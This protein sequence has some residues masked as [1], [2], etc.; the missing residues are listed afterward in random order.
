MLGFYL[1]S[2]MVFVVFGHI[3]YY[4]P[5]TL[6]YSYNI[7]H[8]YVCIY[9]STFHVLFYQLW[10]HE[11]KIFLMLKWCF[12]TWIWQNILRME[13]DDSAK[14]SSHSYSSGIYPFCFA[15]LLKFIVIHLNNMQTKTR[16]PYQVLNIL[17]PSTL[18]FLY[19]H[20]VRLFVC[21]ITDIGVYVWVSPTVNF[22]CYKILVRVISLVG[23]PCVIYGLIA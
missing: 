14:D 11:Q 12:K 2:L 3:P 5:R 16:K 6:K 9:M 1:C 10:G 8:I 15:I 4:S 17:F 18:P 13:R 21:L 22:T 19:V 7:A 20:R 23:L